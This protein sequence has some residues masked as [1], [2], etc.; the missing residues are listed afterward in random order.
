MPI[1]EFVCKSCGQKFEELKTIDDNSSKCPLCDNDS[2]RIMSAAA[3]VV[4]G[5]TN[6]SVDSII[7]E[8][9]N[10]RWTEIENRK[11]NRQ[12][13]L[14]NKKSQNEIKVLEN[15]RQS[16]LL[17]KQNEASQLINKAKQE[18]GI[19]RKDELSHILKG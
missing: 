7:G 4:N 8:D 3:F 14:Y 12:K 5:S 10:K 19:T 6:R 17:K 1:Y 15:K 13:E 9:A 2:E 11:N 16:S 18:A